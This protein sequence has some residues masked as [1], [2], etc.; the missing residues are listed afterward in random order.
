VVN[1]T[2]SLQPTQITLLDDLVNITGHQSFGSLDSA[3]EEY[4]EK[5]GRIQTSTC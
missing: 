1:P 2:Y 3:Y 5:A 4:E